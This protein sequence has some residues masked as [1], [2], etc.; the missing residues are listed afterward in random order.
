MVSGLSN[1][2]AVLQESLAPVDSQHSYGTQA[3]ELVGEA[4]A[5]SLSYFTASQ[6]GRGEYSGEVSWFNACGEA[7]VLGCS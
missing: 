1:V 7:L 3:V 2:N 5:R 4:Q 6:F